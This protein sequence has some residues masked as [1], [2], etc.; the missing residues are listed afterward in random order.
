MKSKLTGWI[1]WVVGV[2][3]VTAVMFVL[4]AWL[5]PPPAGVLLGLAALLTAATGFLTALAAMRRSKQ[6]AQSKAE[7]DCLRRLTRARNRVEKL[8]DEIQDLKMRGV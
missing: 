1:P 5:G 7:A 3:F 6:E 4:L 8:I 2:V